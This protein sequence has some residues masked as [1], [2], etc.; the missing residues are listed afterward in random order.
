MAQRTKSGSGRKT[1]VA[2]GVEAS[3]PSLPEPEPGVK[4]EEGSPEAYARF[5]GA[6]RALGEAELVVVAVDP[7][8][9]RHN[10]AEG[11]AVMLAAR[12]AVKQTGVV[13]D[14]TA[15]ENLAPLGLALLWATA[16]ARTVDPQ[17][18]TPR[19]QRGRVLRRKLLRVVQGLVGFDLVPQAT[20]DHIV[21]GSGSIDTARDLLAL[22]K[23]FRDDAAKLSGKHPVDEA[24]LSE[25]EQLGSE[26]L[27]ALRPA[28]GKRFAKPNA[29][30]RDRM[31]ERLYTL[32]S[33]A[34]GE[35]ERAA[36][37]LWG[38]DAGKHV[39][40]LRARARRRRKP[41]AGTPGAGPL[42]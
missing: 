23:V 15:I 17:K 41:A 5:E 28:S 39:P 20:V 14:W 6:A 10:A 21:K 18:L 37:A 3:P 30:V 1:G 8:L 35:V 33:R 42:G 31:V 2:A 7:V 26:L 32:L 38:L 27:Q 11:A 19:I 36:G 4:G 16:Q 13:V 25:A 22:A 24:T 9:T 12:S 29:I 40:S 34:Y